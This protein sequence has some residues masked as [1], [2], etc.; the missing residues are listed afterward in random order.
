MLLCIMGSA[1]ETLPKEDDEH[2]PEATGLG[3]RMGTR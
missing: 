2:E 3:A 1:F